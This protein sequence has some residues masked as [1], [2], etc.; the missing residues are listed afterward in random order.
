MKEERI[1]FPSSGIALEGLISINEALSA[2]GG[3]VLCHPHPQRGGNM[4][5]PVIASGVQGASEA[6]FST[7]R[8]N[9][10]GVGESGGRYADGIG[11]QED[12]EAAV[13][14]L[15]ATF[16]ERVHPLILFGYSFGAWAG[17]PVAVRDGRIDGMV[18]VAPP[19]EMYDFDFFKG[20]RKN[21]LIVTGSQDLFCPL[22]VLKEW[23][24]QLEEPKR[25][26]VIQGADHFFFSHHQ[27]LIFPIKEFFRSVS[28][29]NL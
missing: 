15:N 6:G 27:S 4:H 1:V 14:C 3:V 7:L 2:R 21:K 20:C 12:V 10:R 26:T 23:Y 19:L 8:Y 29:E 24:Q 5:H 25:L 18:V 17:M 22:P 9:F 16:A 28:Q 11:E 13:D